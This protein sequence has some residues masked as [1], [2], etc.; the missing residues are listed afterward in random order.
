[1]RNKFCFDLS[2]SM[3][4]DEIKVS[5]DN[6]YLLTAMYPDILYSKLFYFPL[7]N[8]NFITYHWIKTCSL[9]IITLIQSL[10]LQT[11]KLRHREGKGSCLRK[12]MGEIGLK[13]DVWTPKL[14]LF[15]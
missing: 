10:R 1:M 13:P 7:K 8:V 3:S 5:Q 14:W 11:R 6:T 15:P 4:I 2:T 12:V 9:K